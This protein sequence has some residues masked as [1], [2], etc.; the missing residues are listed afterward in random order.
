MRQLP[1]HDHDGGLEHHRLVLPWAT[2]IVAD[3]TGKWDSGPD[4]RSGSVLFVGGWGSV[5]VSH[6]SDMAGFPPGR[7]FAQAAVEA[8]LKAGLRPVEMAQFPAWANPPAEYC[9]RLVR[10]CDVYL[11]VVGFRYGSRVPGRAD[12]VSY[13][14][15]EFLTA[16]EAGMPRLVFVLDEDVGIPRSL[17]DKNSGAVDGFRKRL[18][19][20]GVIV[21][22]VTTPADLA[23]AVLHALYEE[24]LNRVGRGGGQG[25]GMP[26]ESVVRRPWMAPPLDRVVERP[27]LG[28]R[29]V[30]ALTAAGP[31]EVG[32]TTA[33]QGAGGF[34]KTT[35]ATWVCHRME[36]NR[37]FPGGL[38]WVTVGQEVYGAEL[39]ERI[40]DLT[41]ML[42]G[43]RPAISDPDAAGAELGRLL[44][45]REPV[46][47][48][49][50]DVWEQAQLRPFRFGG[51]MCTRLVT[52]RIPNLLSA[53]GPRIL[54]DV[55]SAGQ[56]RELVAYG[57]TGLPDGVMDR[58]AT[59]A[60]RWPV[61]LNLVN[62]V[63]RHRVARG[64]PPEQAV[65][66]IL[67]LLTAHGPA[68]LDPA[69]PGE[70]CRAVATTVDASLCLLDQDDWR[71]Y[72]DL[73]IFAED[74]DIPWDVLA[75]LWPDCRVDAVCEEFVG[76]GL[77]A[78]LRLD[79]P[80]PRLVLH[81]VLR[82]YL[83]SRLRGDD[84]TE[85]HR[86]LVDAA[87]GL[88]PTH[89]EA[90]SRPWWE[91]PAGAG[92]LWR[93]LP[94][95]L[96]D[97]GMR[98]E[99]VA[100]VCDLR[101]V[102]AKTRQFGS[103]VGV[104]ADLALVDTPTAVTLGGALRRA[105]HLFGPID[106][107]DA[108]GATLASRL[109]GVPGL[110]A[111][112]DA[113]RATLP[114]PRLEP[115]WPLPDQ[116]DPARLSA[117]VGH[118][119][120]G[121]GCAFSPDGTLLATVGDDCTAR[122][123]RVADGTQQAV[124]TGH[125]SG[126]WDCAFS[127]DG[128]LLATVGDDRTVRLWQVADGTALAVLTGHTDRV[129][130]CA[131]SPDGTLLATVAD[132]CTARLWRVADGTQQAVLT[133]HTSGVWDCA[134]SPDGTLLATVSDDCTTRLWR[135][136]DGTQQAVLTGHTGGVA[137][138]AFSPDGTLLATGGDGG[139]LRL[140]RMPD[141][142]LRT[143]LTGHAERV[144]RC[145]FSPDGSLIATT[146]HDGTVRLWQMP[147]GTP[148][149][150]LN[151]HTNWVRGCAFSPDGALL[152]TVGDEQAIR[153][154]QVPDGTVQTVLAGDSGN[155]GSCAFSPDGTLLA[156]TS[157][158]TALATTA[159][160]ALWLWKVSDGDEPVL[161]VHADV[162]GR[163]AFSPDGTLLA[164]GSRDGTVKLWRMPDGTQQAV[165]T[166]HTAR[167][168]HCAF[169]P[170][171]TLLATTSRDGTVRLWQVTTINCHCALR[172]AGA[173]LGIAWHPSGTMLCTTGGA[174]TYLLS[175]LP[176]QP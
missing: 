118:T 113:Y 127:P 108:L 85:V 133:G 95:H 147:D 6:T 41:F 88:L 74:V 66:E 17:V 146:A 112:L 37:R 81:D 124:L 75:L 27:E 120:S 135:M 18:H 84:R 176:R 82:D 83:R 90:G 99:L 105:A 162:T 91:L 65:A 30:M 158:D 79:H 164:T 53:D 138:C 93:F 50:D 32:L 148:R 49:V 117:T 63:L 97:A 8:V 14:E 103:A 157:T 144:E 126:V 165:L 100:L 110:Q 26:V 45:E 80:G 129:A 141:G 109:H 44:D 140:W 57:V 123:W 39:A 122:L 71:R 62:G 169:S 48:V 121:I 119:G 115:I 12:A 1:C 13:T 9:Q 55:M 145:A 152:A 168:R 151:C 116:P 61:L 89:D 56:A 96:H 31:A 174:G 47:L 42:S 128:T 114:R 104:E 16:T 64:Q 166:G 5:F 2:V 60:G 167:V 19:Q 86:R 137:G 22:A 46:L 107:P 10:E 54:V 150:A 139:E 25:S 70:R 11:A 58:L 38:L 149:A 173:L 153:L 156:A 20:A 52:T 3:W 28:D 143:V 68:A 78:D 36:I 7:S 23:E 69:R 163:C 67:R 87:A 33:L 35:L 43:S 51:R 106:P 130:G 155:V 72:L 77:V 159:V 132:D 101:W 142:T 102:E 134:F 4:G 175:Y 98:D 21:K 170:D 172:V 161:T 29:L 136:P 24:R 34:G 40:N 73:A 125:T 92:Y 111:V 160:G 76:L 94:Y 171:G 131:F 59:V 154:W 15:L